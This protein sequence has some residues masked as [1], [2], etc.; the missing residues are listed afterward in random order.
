MHMC[1][2]IALVAQVSPCVSFHVIYACALVSGCLSGLSSPVSLLLP[3]VPLPALPDV[4]P[5]AWWD[6][7]GKIPCATPASGAWSLWTMSI[8]SQVV[9]PRTW[10]SQTPMSGTSRPSSDIYFQNALDDTASFSNVPDVDDNELAEFLAVVVDRTGKPVEVRSNNDQFFCDIRNLKSAQSQF[11][12]VTQPKKMISQT[13][14][15][16]QERIAE[17]RESSNAQIRTMLDEQRRTIIAEYCEKVSHH[18]LLAAQAE[19]DRKILQEEWL[20]QQQDF[21]EVHQQDLMKQ[22]ELQKFQNSTFDEFTQEKFIEDQKII[23]EL[24]GRLQELQNEVNCMNDSRDFRDAESICS[25]NSHVTSPPGLFPRHPPFEGLLKPAFISQRQTEEPPNIW[26]TSGISGNVFAHPQISSSAPYPQ[27]L[28]CTWKKTIEEPIHMST[29]EKSGRQKQDQYLRCQSGPSAKNSVI[30]SG[31]DSSKNYGADHQRLQISD[32]HSDK[33]PTPATFACWKIR[34]KTEV[35]TCSQFPTEAML[36]IGEV[37]MVETVDDLKSSSSI[38]SISMPNFEVLDAR[39]ASALNQITQNTRCKKKVSLEEQKAQKRTV[40]FVEDRSLT[41]S[42]ITFGSLE[43][44]ILSRIMWTYSQWFFEKMIFRNSFYR[45]WR[46]SHMMTSW[47]A[48][49]IL[50]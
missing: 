5:G 15:S 13:G 12:L 6:L 19:Q 45:R 10:S 25:G 43:P 46:K 1:S 23:M 44:T 11:P 35:C 16:V 38:Q 41:W 50:E 17:E 8:P 21:R 31:G 36:W 14:G 48:C 2:Y 28:N 9:S 7:H 30:F 26:D 39:I 3:P 40:L 32:L 27:E 18:E 49:K 47:K 42:T 29:A 34:F 20:R 22:K 4:H 24:S 37:E 33:F